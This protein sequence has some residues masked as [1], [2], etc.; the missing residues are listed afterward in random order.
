MSQV[1]GP[2]NSMMANNQAT[3]QSDRP[4]SLRAA[5][6]A[7]H[8]L[9]VLPKD[10]VTDEVLIPALSATTSL[11]V[12]MGYF[13]SSS[14]VELA[15]G[16]ANY[17]KATQSPIKMVISPFVTDY[18]F[19]TLIQNKEDLLELSQ[20]IL[21]DDVPDADALSRHTLECLAWLLFQGRLELK[22]AV[23]RGALFHPKVWLFDST[24]GRA[25]LHGSTNLT[26]SGLSRN[27]EQM[28]LSRDW[29]GEEATFHIERL[30]DEFDD[31]WAGGDVDCVV[32]SLPAAI[33]RKVI[34]RYK[35]E[36]MPD[37]ATF[38]TLWHN[39]QGIDE[40]INS[41]ITVS[42][43]LELPAVLNF[44][45]GEYAHQGRAVRAW[46]D[47][48]RRGILEMATGSGKTITA[49]ICAARL[50][51]ELGSL[52]VVV[53]APYRPLIA[54]W[55]VEIRQFG[56]RPIN[57]VESG[58]PQSRARE[59]SQ[60]GRR[61]QKSYSKA[62]V[63]VV[64]NDTLCTETFITALSR[65][66]SRKVLIADECHNL[67]AMSFMAN[68]PEL[69]EYRL[70]LSA[71]PVRQ[72]DQEGTEALVKYFGDVCFSFTLEEAIG[73][74]L[75]EYDYHVHFVELSSGEMTAWRD[76]TKQIASQAWKLKA[77]KSDPHL[78]NL[79]RQRRLILETAAG[80]MDVL[81][82]LLDEGDVRKLRY[83]L[84]YATDKEPRHLEEANRV[85]EERGVLF[86]QLTQE[87]TRNSKQTEKVLSAF[88]EGRIQVLTAK[89]VLDEG[90]NI[91][92]IKL[93]FILASTTVR[94]QWVQRRGRLLRRCAAIDKTHAVVHDFVVLPTGVT[95]T[96][97][98]QL[99]R[100]TRRMVRSELERV[101]EFAR[102]SRN[103]AAAGGPYDA[104]QRL[105]SLANERVVN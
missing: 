35:T 62:E 57:L 20:Q 71:T 48:G 18:D 92:Q 19:D 87:E 69:F 39:A 64:S 38:M 11:R 36:H 50:Q 82:E 90:V 8:P 24:L 22:I 25:A 59:I 9:Y 78:D 61:L 70:G 65:V 12:M 79:L 96:T 66:K 103:G 60:A 33:E 83:A 88:Q 30:W 29:K 63:L 55:C 105:Q 49:M 15:P 86:H 28:T 42:T 44:E 81:A 58:G 4:L 77:G 72:Y 100:D 26:G 80:K 99:D 40:T 101:W 34:E 67:G 43:C 1:S 6:D 51:D 104:V 31:L 73:T 17:L 102:L 53:S 94:R 76:L 5:L 95:A 91:P 16:L 14:F 2:A 75:T 21:L 32:L 54:Q 68:P 13:S 93:A 27:R 7:A 89:R 46:E 97:A 3:E 74:C 10:P 85:L 23:I 41:D 37:E 45:E 47:A 84:V 56:V 52:L 98:E